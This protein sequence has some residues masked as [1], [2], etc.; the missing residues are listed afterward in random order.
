M[1]NTTRY[2]Y[3]LQNGTSCGTNETK[4]PGWCPEIHDGMICWPETPPGNIVTH[5]CPRYAGFN[6]SKLVYKE[7]WDNGTWFVNDHNHTWSNYTQCVDKDSLEFYKFINF[8]FLVGYTISLV[9]LVFSLGIFFSFRGLK[10]I[11]I[12]VHIQLF[13]SFIFFNITYIIWYKGVVEQVKVLFYNPFWCQLVYVAKEY[14]MVANYMWMFCEALHLHLSIVLVFVKEEKTMKWFHGIGWGFSFII[15]LA[16]SLVRQ[17][18]LQDT[19]VCWINEEGFGSWFIVVPVVI[20][21]FLSMIFLINI[22]RVIIKINNP[23]SPKP[24]PLRIK[25]AVRAAF[26]LIPLFGLQFLLI[27]VKP[28]DEHPLY[29]PYLYTTVIII[30]YQGFCCA[31]LFCFADHDV[32]QSFKRRFRKSISR[33]SCT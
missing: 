13:L 32:H 23:N 1:T 26:L 18:Y 11:R 4:M 21:L 15:V 22:V 7:C 5:S 8:L 9:A 6:E 24:T 30:P 33:S 10:C 31:I 3:I 19:D 12:K 2:H 29:I 16:H 28:E 27:P 14:F 25:R 20:T 17:F